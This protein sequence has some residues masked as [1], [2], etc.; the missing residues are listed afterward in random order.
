MAPKLEVTPPATEP[1][2]PT[3]E[4]SLS[5]ESIAPRTKTTLPS[6]NPKVVTSTTI[7]IE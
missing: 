7:P 6:S 1:N 4:E 3:I 5:Q 2:V